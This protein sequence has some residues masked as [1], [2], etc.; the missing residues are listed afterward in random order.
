M[1]QHAPAPWRKRRNL[2]QAADGSDVALIIGRPDQTLDLV[3]LAPDMLAALKN[4]CHSMEWH[5]NQGLLAKMDY[6]FVDEA[7]A[8]IALLSQAEGASQ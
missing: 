6:R 8:V 3:A 5:R 4:C 1:I 2:I 7:K